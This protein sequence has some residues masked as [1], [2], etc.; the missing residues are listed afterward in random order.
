MIYILVGND[1]KSKSNYIKTLAE[2][3]GR[4]FLN[5]STV[6][7]ELLNNHAVSNSLFGEVPLVIVENL[8]EENEIILSLD[9]LKSLNDSPT[10][11][12]LLEDKLLVSNQKK[13][14]KYATIERFEQKEIKAT[15]K[16]DVF[17]IADAFARKDKVKAWT[18]Y[19]EAIEAGGSPEAI[20]GMLFW[21][22]KTMIL[23]YSKVFPL[24]TLKKLS[25]EIV[26]LHHQAHKGERDFIVG[27]EQFILKSLS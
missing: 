7:K 27:L 9:D 22:I 3:R 19:R 8:I 14:E 11:F 26:S 21:K 20:S 18:L 23:N 15:P 1:T 5:S 12:I 6:S 17:A 24:D 4:V 16:T 13:Y 2:G 10:I 25:S